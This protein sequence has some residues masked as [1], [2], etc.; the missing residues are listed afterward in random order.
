MNTCVYIPYVCVH[1]I[2]LI[3]FFYLINYDT[4]MQ[5]RIKY[6]HIYIYTDIYIKFVYD[7]NCARVNVAV[8][9][10]RHH[11]FVVGKCIYVYT[12]MYMYI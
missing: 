11:L 5:I 3:K 1:E 10:A 7:S 2:N 4:F 8:S 12:Y 6:L 9:R